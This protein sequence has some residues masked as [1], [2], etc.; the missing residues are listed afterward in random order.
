M[1]IIKLPWWSLAR[2]NPVVPSHWQAT[3]LGVVVSLRPRL[4]LT[5]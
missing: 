2:D 1:N 5:G 4:V 3:S